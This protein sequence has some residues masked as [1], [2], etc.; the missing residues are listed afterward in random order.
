MQL[1]TF[2]IYICIMFTFVNSCVCNYHTCNLATVYNTHE[3]R[4]WI[5]Q[6]LS[7]VRYYHR[8]FASTVIQPLRAVLPSVVSFPHSEFLPSRTL[9]GSGLLRRP[10]VVA[11]VVRAPFATSPAPSSRPR[12]LSSPAPPL[13]PPLLRRDIARA[14]QDY[15]CCCLCYIII[16]TLNLILIM[17]L[18]ICNILH[19]IYG[20]L[21]TY[22][23]C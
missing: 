14:P 8:K 17:M 4:A 6:L 5:C 2:V 23:N 13:A 11:R 16:I 19:I 7:V 21:L 10:S 12:P 9:L 3:Y 22:C 15:L 1:F 20:L 18:T